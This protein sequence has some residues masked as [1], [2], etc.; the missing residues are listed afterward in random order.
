MQGGAPNELFRCITFGTYVA[1]KSLFLDD[2]FAKH[3]EMRIT[4]DTMCAY[5]CTP[6]HPA[7]PPETS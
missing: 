4:L 1:A 5:T 2:E 7:H 6:G 3:N